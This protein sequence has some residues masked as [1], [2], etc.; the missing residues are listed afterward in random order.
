MDDSLRSL[1]RLRVACKQQ[2]QAAHVY[3][4]LAQCMARSLEVQIV[5]LSICGKRRYCHRGSLESTP[6]ELAAAIRIADDFLAADTGTIMVTNAC[7]A[8]G[9]AAHLA[10]AHS[11]LMNS[12]AGMRIR[13]A[14][15]TIGT[16]CL[17]DR[18]PGAIRMI[19]LEDMLGLAEAVVASVHA[20]GR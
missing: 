2:A 19:L 20:R 13:A 14:D 16:L 9:L 12:F 11:A 6:A 8:P 1:D 4:D 17:F 10:M 15:H 18:R 3:G 7:P 5:L